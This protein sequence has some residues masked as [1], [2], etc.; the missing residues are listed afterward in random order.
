MPGNREEKSMKRVGLVLI[1]GSG[2]DIVDADTYDKVSS[3]CEGVW[4]L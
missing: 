1:V 3:N 4:Y 2:Y